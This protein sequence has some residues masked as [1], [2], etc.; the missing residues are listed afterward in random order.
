MARSPRWKVYTNEGEY[1]ASCKYLDDAG[2][3][4]GAHCTTGYTIRDGH[5]T[6]IFTQGV[7]GDASDSYDAPWVTHQRR[8]DPPA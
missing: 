2:A 6:T 5:H 1:I 8:L 7:D 4:V 3:I